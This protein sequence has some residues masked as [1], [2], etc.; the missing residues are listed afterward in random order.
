MTTFLAALAAAGIAN[1]GVRFVHASDPSLVVLT[2]HF[3]AVLAL[4]SLLP[5]A[6]RR[7]FN[8]R[9]LTPSFS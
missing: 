5:L 4:A 3:G 2:W 1:F 6:G 7:L 9:Q 8:W